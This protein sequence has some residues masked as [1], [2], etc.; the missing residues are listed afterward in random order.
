MSLKKRVLASTMLSAAM[1]VAMGGMASAQVD[2]IVVTA[3]KTEQDSQSIPVAVSAI[4]ADDLAELDVD[5]FADY[6]VQ[7][8][9]VTAGGS[10]PGQNTIYIRGVAST[11]PNLTTAGVA[12]LAPNVAF[13][14]DEQPLAQP[15]RNLDV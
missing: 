6:L 5:V 2:R 12:G 9:G 11:T 10:G 8:P 13:Y 3:T 15:G 14:L 4:G 1:G 7:L